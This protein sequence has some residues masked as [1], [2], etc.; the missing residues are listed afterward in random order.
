MNKGKGVYMG[1]IEEI[2]SLVGNRPLILIG[3]EVITHVSS[4][5]QKNNF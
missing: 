1:Y 5:F 3:S 2:R 4:K